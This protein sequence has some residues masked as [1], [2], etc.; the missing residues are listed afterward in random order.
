[1]GGCG[2]SFAAG[3]VVAVIDLDNHY[4]ALI[5]T[6]DLVLQHVPGLD[7]F[8]PADGVGQ[9]QLVSMRC[10]LRTAGA[11]SSMLRSMGECDCWH[12]A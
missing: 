5:L 12:G 1:M 7:V 2:H 10:M 3:D 9:Q 4:G 8:M 6:E 11:G